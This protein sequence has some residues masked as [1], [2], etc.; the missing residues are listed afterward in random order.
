[1]ALP[2]CNRA[3]QNLACRNVS[4]T[5]ECTLL[6][7]TITDRDSKTVLSWLARCDSSTAA[8][9]LAD[10]DSNIVVSCR[11]MW[12]HCTFD[13]AVLAFAAAAR[14]VSQF[15][16]GGSQAARLRSETAIEAQCHTKMAVSCGW[17]LTAIWMWL[18]CTFDGAVLAFA[19]A[20]RSVSQFPEQGSQAAR[21]A[22]L[23]A[24]TGPGLCTQ[25]D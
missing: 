11:W 1:M 7:C 16:E 18:H 10:C 4:E 24:T 8:F 21:I 25:L 13:G 23:C 12:L 20:A 19:A 5:Q 2:K 22:G 14:S 17:T 3:E 15:P 6:A 9:G